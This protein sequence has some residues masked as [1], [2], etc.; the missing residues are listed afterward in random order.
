M[1]CQNVVIEGCTV[2]HGHGGFVIGSEM[3]SGARNI[4]VNNCLFNGTDTGLRLKSTRGRGGIVENI[5]VE[6][7]N[8]V[9][10]KGDA[11]TFD[12]YYANKP[13]AGKADNTTS[14]ADAVPPV[15]E[16]TPCFRNLYISNIICQ[17][18]KRAIYFNGLP[19]MPLD[20]LQLKNS[21]FVSEKGAELK[22]AKN[23]LFDNVKI[24]NSQG[25][26]LVKNNVE[27]LTEK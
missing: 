17:G 10:I 22:Y 15:T 18:A 21:L 25:D 1:P 7:I 23:I 11:F 13:V 27:N 26:R 19:E 9:D 5:Y 8:M 3:S 2:L 20:N 24:V 16:E 6:N 14:E 12:L 4:Y